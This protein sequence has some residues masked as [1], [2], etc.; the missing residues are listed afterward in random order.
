MRFLVQMRG[1]PANRGR[2]V[3]TDLLIEHRYQLLTMSAIQMLEVL[4]L[5]RGPGYFCLK[6]PLYLIGL[7]AMHWELA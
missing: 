5:R 7:K 2:I 3:A 6:A 4:K 1:Y